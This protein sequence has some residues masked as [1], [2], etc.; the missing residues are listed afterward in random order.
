VINGTV[1]YSTEITP[2]TKDVSADDLGH[3]VARLDVGAVG[4]RH[5]G[6]GLAGSRGALNATQIT[7]VL[8]K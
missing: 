6:E 5:E 1:V 3:R 4:A 7:D 2:T 8:L